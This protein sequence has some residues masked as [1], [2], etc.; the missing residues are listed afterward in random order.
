MRLGGPVAD[1]F[2]ARLLRA[3]STAIDRTPSFNAMAD[4]GTLAVRASGRH[5]V[6]RTFEAVERHRLT[7]LRDA[8][9]LS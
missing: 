1:P 5:R 4:H 9:A 8:K 7:G 3:M 2:N 6:D